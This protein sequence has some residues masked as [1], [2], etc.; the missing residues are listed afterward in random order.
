MLQNIIIILSREEHS[1][2]TANANSS[3]PRQDRNNEEKRTY[4]SNNQQR[5]N[6]TYDRKNQGNDQKNQTGER[7][8]YHNGEKRSYNRD[9]QDGRVY[10]KDAQEN[11][12]YNKNRNAYDSNRRSVNGAKDSRGYQRND[13]YGGF[14]KDKDY[15]DEHD[16]TANQRVRETKV[17]SSKEREQQSDKLETIKRIEREKKAMQKKQENNK[18]NEKVSARVPKKQKRANNID[19]TKG[20]E[21]G[22]YGDDDEDYTEYM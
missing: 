21:N 2:V 15:G 16:K 13:S 8:T 10:Q 20:Y 14:R 1:V 19:W 17:S 9:G 3:R 12:S 5:D 7:K 4:K 6:R 22:L 18:K 11:R